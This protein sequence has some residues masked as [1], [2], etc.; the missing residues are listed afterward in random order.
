[1]DILHPAVEVWVSASVV[2]SVTY[3]RTQY[4]PW[5]GVFFKDG[6]NILGVVK[7]MLSFYTCDK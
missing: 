1:M 5:I 6:Q 2:I 3:I 7:Y 4:L